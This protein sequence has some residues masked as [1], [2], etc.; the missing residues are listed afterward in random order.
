[1]ERAF[2]REIPERWHGFEARGLLAGAHGHRF[3]EVFYARAAA[4]RKPRPRRQSYS[5]VAV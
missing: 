1:M 3:G 2:S 4:V 5:A